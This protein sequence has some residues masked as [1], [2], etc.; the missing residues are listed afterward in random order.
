METIED[1]V[2]DEAYWK[3]GKKFARVSRAVALSGLSDFSG[4]RD[5]DREYYFE[6][7]RQN[8]RLFELVARGEAEGYTFD[9][10]IEKYRAGHAAFLRDT[11]FRPLPG[12]IEKTVYAKWE[13]FGVDGEGTGYEGIA[14]TMDVFGTVG[15]R[16]WLPDYKTGS[17]SGGTGIQTGFYAAMLHGYTFEEIERFGVAILPNGKYKMTP[18]YPHTDKNDAFYCAAQLAKKLKEESI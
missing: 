5:K 7:G 12:G 17:V 9:P 8:H 15:N 18:R 14:G 13:V 1:R 6:R 10:E 11:G 16:L 4:I 3:N 2:T